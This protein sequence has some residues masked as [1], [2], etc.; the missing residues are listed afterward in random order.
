MR[1]L[2]RRRP[3]WFRKVTAGLGPE[4]S[5]YLSW[6]RCLP[7]PTGFELIPWDGLH[8]EVRRCRATWTACALAARAADAARGAQEALDCHDSGETWRRRTGNE[9]GLF[10]VEAAEWL[11]EREDEP[12]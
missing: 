2:D 3:R 9:N 4:P 10:L 6:S 1:P 5:G 8:E 12:A 11:R 7:T